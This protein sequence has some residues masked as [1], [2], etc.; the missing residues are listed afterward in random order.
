MTLIDLKK[1]KNKKFDTKLF[2]FDIIKIIFFE[3]IRNFHW[4]YFTVST[5]K[6]IENIRVWFSLT[7]NN[8]LVINREFIFKIFFF[9]FLFFEIEFNSNKSYLFGFGAFHNYK[10]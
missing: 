10:I 2:F 7:N 8:V 9:L 4:F 5:N 6:E 3:R 1:I